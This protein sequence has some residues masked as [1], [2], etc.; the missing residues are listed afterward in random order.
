MKR[1]EEQLKEIKRGC[2]ELITEQE[3]IEK[4]KEGKPLRIKAGFDPTAADLHLGHTV[5]LHK[6]RQFQELG[7][8]VVFLLGDYTA[9]IGDPSG[10][11]ETRPMLSPEQVQEYAKTYEDQVFKILDR[12]KTEVRR[13][14]EWLGKMTALEFIQLTSKYTAARMLERDDFEKRMNA[15]QDIAL[16]EFTYP[17]LQ[18]YDSVVLKADVEI[19]GHDQKFNLLLG[20]TIQKRYG[21]KSQVTLT[22]PLL[23][24]TDGVNKMSKSYNN[25]VGISEAPGEMF[26]KLMAIS[27]ILM[28]NYYELLST[29][30]LEEIAQLKK[31]VEEG[32]FHPKQAKVNLAKE[33]VARFHSSQAA[34]HAAEEFDR[35]FKQKDLPE[36]IEEVCYSAAQLPLILVDVLAQ[37][38]LVESKTD[39]KRMIAQSAVSVN[40]ERV[41]DA[42]FQFEK[43]GEYLLKVGKRKFK[44]LKISS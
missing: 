27:D 10:R 28:W 14:S 37:E 36:N 22:M 12:Q 30:S 19:G 31:S 32:K 29:L 33:I 39:A 2:S 3:L 20:R 9:T 34:E 6:L 26:G 13:N 38:K 21:Q 8:Q 18:A 1:V 7:H 42:K 4:I 44:K 40:G 16:S 41:S 23:V 24:G 43:T 15:D 35:V 11:S 25:Y 5:L 17:L